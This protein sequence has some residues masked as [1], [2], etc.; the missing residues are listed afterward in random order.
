[1]ENKQII[2]YLVDRLAEQKLIEASYLEKNNNEEDNLYLH[3]VIKNESRE[4]FSKHIQLLF[5]EMFELTYHKTIESYYDFHN[6]YLK[7][8]SDVRVFLLVDIDN[9]NM[10]KNS[11]V[12]FDPNNLL[13]V[14]D[15]SISSKIIGDTFNEISYLLDIFGT[16]YKIK[17][18]VKAMRILNDVNKYVL[19]FLNYIY[20]PDKV[21]HNYREC[22]NLLPE[23]IKNDC[24]KIIKK[25]RVDS[26]L[27][28]SNMMLMLLDEQVSK[29]S[30]DVAFYVNMDFYLS[31]KRSIFSF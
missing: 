16:A 2:R 3:V 24:I 9:Y 17:D 28:C 18:L 31:V 20:L 13:V 7:F 12:L 14:A 22:L 25:L 21:Y 27:E 1:M 23:N 15:H 29:I 8:N 30:I 4:L 26:L 11:I 10:L 5:C 19:R 6:Y